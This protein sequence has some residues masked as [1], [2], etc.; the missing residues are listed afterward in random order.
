MIHF[1]QSSALLPGATLQVRDAHAMACP[2][3]ISFRN[4]APGEEV[5]G[6]CWREAAPMAAIPDV[7]DCRLRIERLAGEARAQTMR[8][9][10]DFR[11]HGRIVHISEHAC[12][13]N[14]NDGAKEP[15]IAAL[16]TVIDRGR[17]AAAAPTK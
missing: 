4:L 3:H 5:E 16:R 7:E 14:G 13:R 15:L 10:L 17:S 12:D 2:I 8:I 11:I 6:A 9:T 1:E